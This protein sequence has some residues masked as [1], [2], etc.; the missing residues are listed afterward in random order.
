MEVGAGA[1]L[2]A[3]I[4]VIN[5]NGDYFWLDRGHWTRS[6]NSCFFAQ[7]WRAPARCG[8][9][10]GFFPFTLLYLLLY[11]TTFIPGGPC[12]EADR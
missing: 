7:G 10:R 5:E 3:K 11:A 12:A 6:G 8:R 4:F 1:A 9:W 2:P